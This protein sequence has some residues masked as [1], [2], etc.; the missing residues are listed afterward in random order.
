MCVWAIQCMCYVAQWGRR[1][2]IRKFGVS[3]GGTR[4]TVH[5]R[6]Y[7]A[8]LSH[9]NTNRPG[10]R[11]ITWTT[12]H[13]IGS[14]AV[15]PTAGPHPN[16]LVCREPL[17]CSEQSIKFIHIIYQIPYNV[18]NAILIILH[19]IHCRPELHTRPHFTN[20]YFIIT[21]YFHNQFQQFNNS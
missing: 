18:T 16:I 20:Y 9:R 3:H 2:C 5:V 7:D 14:S 6:V 17:S 15:P 11:R 13:R 4:D 19:I 1:I 21:I 10:K 12:S 8:G